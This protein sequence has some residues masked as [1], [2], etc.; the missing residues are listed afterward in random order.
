MLQRY[1]VQK[2]HDNERLPLVL[3][4]FVDGA[5]VGMVQGR[6][7][8]CFAAKTFQSLRNLRDI[9]RQ[10]LEGDEAP[11]LG[12]LGLV[13]HTHAAAAQFLDNAVVRDGLADHGGVSGCNVRGVTRQSQRGAHKSPIHPSPPPSSIRWFAQECLLPKISMQ[14]QTFFSSGSYIAKRGNR[15]MSSAR[16]M[17]TRPP[18]PTESIECPLCL[19]AGKLKRTEVLDRLGMTSLV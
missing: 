13:N 15:T 12:V 1:A 11:K 17:T 16:T 19:G 7:G 3:P 8:A 10:K 9:F 18:V 14:N 4:N 5:D 2:L 6:S